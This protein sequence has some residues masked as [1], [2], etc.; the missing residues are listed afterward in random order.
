MTYVSLLN[1]VLNN[2]GLQDY[3]NKKQLSIVY[4]A[5]PKMGTE[6]QQDVCS[7]C[8]KARSQKC[9][10]T[11]V[12]LCINLHKVMSVIQVKM[13]NNITLDTQEKELLSIMTS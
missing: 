4:Y 2:P 10:A 12:E 9:T 8:K 3:K 6:Q 5:T 1:W 13:D 11:E 7:F